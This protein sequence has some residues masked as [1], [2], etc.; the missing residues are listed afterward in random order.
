MTNEKEKSFSIVSAC[1][2]VADCKY[3]DKASIWLI[4]L[5]YKCKNIHIIAVRSFQEASKH[6]LNW[7][8]EGVI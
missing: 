1:G 3:D 6:A 2:R 8:A 5:S 4:N 7:V